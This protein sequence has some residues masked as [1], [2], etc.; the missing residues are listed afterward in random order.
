M[1]GEGGGREGAGG[2]TGSGGRGVGRNGCHDGLGG[3]GRRCNERERGRDGWGLGHGWD[4]VDRTL[5]FGEDE[6][7][8]FD[9]RRGRGELEGL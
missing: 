2:H 4:H 7:R 9:Y 1:G 5:G 8:G 6:G 3:G